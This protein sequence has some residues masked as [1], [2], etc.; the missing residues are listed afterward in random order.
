MFLGELFHQRHVLLTLV[1]STLGQLLVH[2]VYAFLHLGDV[3]KGFLSLLAHRRI[4][5]QN[6]DLGQIAYR[7]VVW[8][9]D[10]ST[11]RLLQATQ[12]F[13]QRRLSRAVL[14]HQGDTVTIVDHETGVGKQGLDAKL[15]T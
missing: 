7:G 6:H 12:D 2:P 8:H 10:H 5:L 3:G 15:H 11:R 4:V 14:T 13:E 9:A 1:V